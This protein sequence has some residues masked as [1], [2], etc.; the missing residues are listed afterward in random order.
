MKW[1]GITIKGMVSE[2]KVNIGHI[3]GK[4]SLFECAN[5]ILEYVLNKNLER[6]SS[7]HLCPNTLWM[8][9]DFLYE[10]LMFFVH[11]V[12]PPS[13]GNN[14]VMPDFGRED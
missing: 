2:T 13:F 5:R 7:I 14:Q 6:C 4:I 12:K 1:S 10:I 8:T 9:I 11:I 3:F